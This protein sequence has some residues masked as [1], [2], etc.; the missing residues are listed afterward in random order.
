MHVNRI[1]YAFTSRSKFLWAPGPTLR[2][3]GCP[4]ERPLLASGIVIYMTPPSVMIGYLRC[5]DLVMYVS[6]IS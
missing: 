6:D 2:T 4:Y 5:D 1:T 3:R